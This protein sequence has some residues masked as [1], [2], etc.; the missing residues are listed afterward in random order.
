MRN[1]IISEL[2]VTMLL[3]APMSMVACGPRLNNVDPDGSA[4]ALALSEETPSADC[5]VYGWSFLQFGTSEDDGA[6]ALGSD[7][8]CNVFVAGNTSGTLSSDGSG[9]GEHQDGFVARLNATTRPQWIT[10]LGTL[11]LD[12]LRGIAVDRTGVSYVI[13]DSCDAVTTLAGTSGRDVFAARIEASGHRQWQVNAGSMADAYGQGIGLRSDGSLLAVSA[14][15]ADPLKS[16]DFWLA[17]LAADRG[18]ISEAYQFGTDE[19]DRP[20][21]LLLDPKS[22]DIYLSGSTSGDLDGVNQGSFDMFL[23]KLNKD[24]SPKWFKQRGTDDV[25][26]ALRV[27][28]DSMGNLYVLA[29]SY[30]NLAGGSESDGISSLF[31]VKFDATGSHQWTKRVGRAAA[32]ASGAGLAIS[33]KD[34]IYVAGSTTG[35]LDTTANLGGR[36]AFLAKYTAGGTRLWLRQFGTAADDQATSVVVTP[37]GQVLVAGTTNGEM[38][39]SAAKGKSDVFIARFR[40]DGSQD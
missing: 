18:T 37:G 36:D 39:T 4:D 19:Y 8:N 17:R 1:S 35:A 29:L 16:S 32:M 15:F 3:F 26:A 25:D 28:R 5:I 20:E 7:G 34:L 27:V 33:G 31:L 38:V 22:D 13:G 40:P 12:T 23:G 30:A 21:S 2:A 9:R 11:Q 6:V 24:Y 10:Q 14:T